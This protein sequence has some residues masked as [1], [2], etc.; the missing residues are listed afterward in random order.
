[1][2]TDQSQI[3]GDYIKQKLGMSENEKDW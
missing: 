1:V 3:V 2:N